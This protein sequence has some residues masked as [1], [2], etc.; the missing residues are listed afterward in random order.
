MAY[1]VNTDEGPSQANLQDFTPSF[2]A[3]LGATIGS[4]WDANITPLA[5]SGGLEA[6][7]N[8]GARLDRMSAEQIVKDAG[9][10]L[11]VPESG[12]TR[13]ALD[14]LISRQRDERAR[15]S[16]L[17]RTPWSWVGS[18]VRGAASLLTAALDPVN[19]AAA[20]IPVVGEAR[21]VQLLSR[22][23]SA[24]GRAGAR[25]GIGAVEG[26]VGAAVLE[27]AV[28]ALHQQLQDDYGMSDSLRNLAF[29]GVFGGGLHVAGGVIGDV[30]RG[31][32]QLARYQGLSTGEI[33][34][35]MRFERQRAEDI[36]AG[37]VTDITASTEGWTDRMRQAAGVPGEVPAK[38]ESRRTETSASSASG[39][40]LASAEPAPFPKLADLQPGQARE[41]AIAGLRDELRAELLQDTAGR[42]EPRVIAE[43]RQ[44]LAQLEQRLSHLDSEPEFKQRA[45]LEQQGASRKQAE[46]AA[47]K[48]IADERADLVATRDRLQSTVDTNARASKAD[49]EMASL[50]RGEVPERFADR[51]QKRADEIMAS[52]GI[53]RA[54]TGELAPPA[55]WVIGMASPE[56]RDAALR[57]AVAD[58]AQ[59]RIPDVAD[60]VRQGV[61][62]M[63]PEDM[64]ARTAR[65]TKP[66]TLAVGDARDSIAADRR[67]EA[68]GAD[69][70]LV[71][72]QQALQETEERRAAARQALETAGVSTERIA[73]LEK[74]L[75]PYDA[76]VN[77]SKALGN[78]ARAAAICGIRT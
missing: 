8:R 19:V 9:A 30:L 72:A 44:Q 68:K 22:A 25:A 15:Q 55:H 67:L 11:K 21:A 51:V 40:K 45:K 74:E 26:T 76:A 28:Y 53:A 75:E 41:S 14:L 52:A 50:D 24:V 66:E 16:I 33:G 70:P 58:M 20:F 49:Q 73:A 18:P 78:A 31:A 69:E 10:S 36:S 2:G 27:P 43:T 47:R 42:A 63:K 12:Y 4:A 7:S 57:T 17:N 5:V 56:T 65:Q 38:A 35:V 77:D 13:E 60:I 34:T 32:P 3:S 6:L 29:G 61:K 39:A 59:G 46:A 62:D 37:R 54:V 48:S 64:A 23:G 71:A 1:Y